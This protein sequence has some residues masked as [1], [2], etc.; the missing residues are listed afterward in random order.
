MMVT[1]RA[2]KSDRS[3]DPK[4]AKKLLVGA[5]GAVALA[6][7]VARHVAWYVAHRIE[8]SPRKRP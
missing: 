1:M 3:Y 8:P 6:V 2:G 5:G 4:M 7:D